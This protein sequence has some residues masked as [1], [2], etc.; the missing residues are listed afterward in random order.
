MRTVRLFPFMTSVLLLAAA[1]GPHPG[2]ATTND[3]WSALSQASKQDVNSFMVSGVKIRLIYSLANIPLK[4]P[5]IRK[6]GFPVV[7]VAEETG[8]LE[9]RQNRFL[10]TGDAK[11]EEDQTMWW[12]PLGIKSGPELATQQPRALVSK[13]DTIQGLGHDSFY[14]INKDLSGFYRT[15]YSPDRLEK[16]GQSLGSL[17]TE[18]KIGLIGD[19]AALAVS[20]EGTT[21][22]LLSLLEGFKDEKN[23]L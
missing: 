14:K 6:I 7:T 8:Q 9:I 15:N 16:L 13:A 11:P 12:I 22:A 5:W 4:D 19:A 20:G 2:N 18:D 23:Y 10:S 1:N 17:S 3:L 21:A